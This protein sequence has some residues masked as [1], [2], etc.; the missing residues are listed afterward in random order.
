MLFMCNERLTSCLSSGYYCNTSSQVYLAGIKQ[1]IKE[2]TAT[3][4]V[5]LSQ[6]QYANENPIRGTKL[7]EPKRHNKVN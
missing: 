5:G 4:V 2:Q 6:L 7:I 3:A 1:F